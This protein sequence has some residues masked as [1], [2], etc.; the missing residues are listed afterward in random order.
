[1]KEAKGGDRMAIWAR[2]SSDGFDL[3]VPN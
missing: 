3:T 2:L 1:L